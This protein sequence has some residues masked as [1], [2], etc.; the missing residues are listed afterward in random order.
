MSRGTFEVARA[1]WGSSLR[2]AE[3]AAAA[4]VLMRPPLCPSR[5]DLNSLFSLEPPLIGLGRAPLLAY[6]LSLGAKDTWILI[7]HL[8]PCPS[9][10]PATCLSASN[11]CFPPA[12]LTPLCSSLPLP[13]GPRLCGSPSLHFSLVSYSSASLFHPHPSC[14]VPP[15]LR[16]P[17]LA[18]QTCP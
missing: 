9:V 1:G 2:G 10:P 3:G 4:K 18:T 15:H 6:A 17:Y 16:L 12:F 11:L 5:R 14:C 8:W 13:L 7:Q